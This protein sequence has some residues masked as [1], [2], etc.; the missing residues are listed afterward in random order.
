LVFVVRNSGL[1]RV[2]IFQL[3]LIE[4]FDKTKG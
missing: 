2:A 3:I 4:L 1:G